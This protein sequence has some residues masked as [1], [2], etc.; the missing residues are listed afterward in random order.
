MAI[1]SKLIWR[2]LIFRQSSRES[3]GVLQLF[4]IFI[5]SLALQQISSETFSK[6][7]NCSVS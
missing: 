3:T 2:A 6:R 4:D 7:S 1:S 5:Q